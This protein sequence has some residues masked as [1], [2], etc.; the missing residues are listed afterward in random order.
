MAA[1]VHFVRSAAAPR[2]EALPPPDRAAASHNIRLIS[3]EYWATSGGDRRRAAGELPSCWDSG[4]ADSLSRWRRCGPVCALADP[5]PDAN[6]RLGSNPAVH[7]ALDHARSRI[8]F[9]SLRIGLVR[10]RCLRDGGGATRRRRSRGSTRRDR[11]GARAHTLRTEAEA[12]EA[13]MNVVP[14][15][16]SSD[17]AGTGPGAVER[18]CHVVVGGG[19]GR[20]KSGRSSCRRLALQNALE[21]RK[22]LL[23]CDSCCSVRFQPT[24]L[25]C[26]AF[27]SPKPKSHAGRTA[28]D[29]KAIP[30]Y[31]PGAHPRVTCTM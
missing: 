25:V 28:S 3:V 30:P 1:G 2:R 13:V 22:I 9:S 19:T 12:A 23:I 6:D 8:S 26:E 4:S 11:L 31:P 21:Q 17:A 18:S 7:D 24:V 5:T 14:R 20:V 15:G 27:S 29:A 10:T 16:T